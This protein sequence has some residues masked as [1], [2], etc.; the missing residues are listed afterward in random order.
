LDLLRHQ[1]LVIVAAL[2]G[3]VGLAW[4]WL[5][6]AAAD[7]DAA[8]AGMDRA[9]AMPP[10]GAV[11]L[12]LLF[13]MW[14]IMMIGMMLPS[15]AP[16][17][18]TFASVNGNRRARGRP[19]VPTTLFVAGYLLAWGGFSL[20]ATAAQWALERAA[21]LSP[22]DMAVSGATNGR[23]L[24]GALFVAAGLYQFTPFKQACLRLCWSPLEFVANR[25]RDGAAGALAMGVT[26]GLY[27]LGCCWFLML[28]LFAVGV[29]NLAWV[30]G[31][32]VVVLLEKVLPWGPWLGRAG[33]VVLAAYG[34]WLLA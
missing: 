26:H 18:L 28:L 4:A 11:D 32:A 6:R 24:G 3:I 5:V 12:L 19:W 2:A 13:A 20:A 27:C 9:M 16:M 29:M 21:L 15:A 31:L 34:V 25:W 1:R 23:W 7:M 22:M 14:W 33:G 8:M 10:P 17:I 30:A